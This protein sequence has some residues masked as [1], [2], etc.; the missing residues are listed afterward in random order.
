[1][2]SETYKSETVYAV[3]ATVT[4]KERE[5]W[6]SS[7]QIPT[8]FLHANVQGICGE[9]DAENIAR[10]ILGVYNGNGTEVSVCA[11]EV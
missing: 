11:T 5:G 1:M 4:T 3:T 2:K 10:R 8:F 7:R 9:R 6:T